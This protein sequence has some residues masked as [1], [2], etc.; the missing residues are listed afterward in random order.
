MK[1][2]LSPEWKNRLRHFDSNAAQIEQQAAAAGV[3]MVAVLVPYRSQASMISMGEWPAGYN[4]YKLDDELRAIIT[5]HGGTYVSILPGFRSVPNAEQYYLPIDGHPTA[6]GHAILAELLAKALTSGAVP[7][8][9][10]A[11]LAQNANGPRK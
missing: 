2:A 9:R 1:D 11:S 7:D 4:P 10:G 8:L 3:P 5:S 6:E